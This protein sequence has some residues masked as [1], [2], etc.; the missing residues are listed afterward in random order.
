MIDDQIVFF[1]FYSSKCHTTFEISKVVGL[2]Q[3]EVQK[4]LHEMDD[5]GVVTM[6][7]GFYKLSS[8]ARKKTSEQY[9]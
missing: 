4:T 6:R 8:H 9:G 3:E 7:N 5:S 2:T 1:L